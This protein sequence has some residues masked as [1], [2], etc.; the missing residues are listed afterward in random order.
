MG[1]YVGSGDRKTLRKTINLLL[2]WGVGLSAIFSL[3]YLGFGR[4]LLGLFTDKPDLVNL[5]MVFMA[6]TVAAPVINGIC[7]VWD[8]IFIGATAT[9]TMRNSMIIATVAVFLPVYYLTWQTLG[10][11]ALW[12][13]MLAY[14]I[15]RGVTLWVAYARGRMLATQ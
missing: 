13:A 8:G 6:W 14:M 3:V 4:L 1:K 2:W 12:L 11:H 7:F 5:A 15:A 9:A 10:N